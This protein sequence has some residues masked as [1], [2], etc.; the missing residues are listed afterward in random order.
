MR[1]RCAPSCAVHSA[2]AASDMSTPDS[3]LFIDALPVKA[4]SVALLTVAAEQVARLDKDGDCVQSLALMPDASYNSETRELRGFAVAV[5]PTTAPDVDRFLVALQLEESALCCG[6]SAYEIRE[7]TKDDTDMSDE[8]HVDQR[9]QGLEE[10]I[11]QKLMSSL[12]HVDPVLLHKQL[13]VGVY[14]GT[15]SSG[16][17]P[18]TVWYLYVRTHDV[19]GSAEARRAWRAKS[20]PLLELAGECERLRRNGQ[21]IR[22][23]VAHAVGAFYGARFVK[24]TRKAFAPWTKP[25]EKV[26]ARVVDA[27]ISN[28]WNVVS[29]AGD[30][31][32][33]FY[34]YSIPIHHA[35]GGIM[36]MYTRAFGMAVLG[37]SATVDG[38]L[39]PVAA[40]RGT[41][42]AFPRGFALAQRD[43]AADIDLK[44][45]THSADR[46]AI[47]TR[48]IQW[49]PRADSAPGSST[50][51][52]PDVLSNRYEH[53]VPTASEIEASLR[54]LGWTGS[55][56]TILVLKR[57]AL[58][59]TPHDSAA[60]SLRQ[61][62]NYAE[63]F[64]PATDSDSEPTVVV[65]YGEFLVL[66]TK[67]HSK[68]TLQEYAITRFVEVEPLQTL[69]VPT[70]LMRQ[71]HEYEKAQSQ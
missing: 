7:F 43:R 2:A 11:Q 63:A 20:T 30:V 34:A 61:R 40:S 21:F 46:A 28:V 12:R 13:D 26:T 9:T 49:T 22:D 17:Q 52:H 10:F 47:E 62:I 38:S 66:Y 19:A 25:V 3:K 1:R 35:V 5:A 15:L 67:Y 44:A 54:M 33:A 14:S 39:V 71:L 56:R 36:Y 48:A 55:D 23:S 60:L 4:R 41:L 42:K 59:I 69:R 24:E 16:V 32:L 45:H 57:A 6:A 37:S 31:S 51:L 8:T 53:A 65:A 50:T 70:A 64:H 27:S 58:H 68:L 29:A 18:R